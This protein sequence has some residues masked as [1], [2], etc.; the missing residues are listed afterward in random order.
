MGNDPD[1]ESILT[2]LADVISMLYHGAIM[3]KTR[4]ETASQRSQAIRDAELHENSASR[5]LCPYW[6]GN[7]FLTQA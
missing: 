5:F 1:V 3:L 6:I 4:Q 7:P 2:E